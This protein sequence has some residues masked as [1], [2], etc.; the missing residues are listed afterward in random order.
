[1]TT[2]A[3]AALGFDDEHAVEA[4]LVELGVL[5]EEQQ[6]ALSAGQEAQSIDAVLATGIREHSGVLWAVWCSVCGIPFDRNKYRFRR[7]R[8]TPDSLRKVPIP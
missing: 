7:E 5:G 4:F 6:H 8:C 2:S 1:V 3:H